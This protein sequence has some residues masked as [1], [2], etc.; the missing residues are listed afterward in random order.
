[1]IVLIPARLDSTRFPGK[2]LAPIN[3]KS[4]LQ[5]LSEALAVAAPT[6]HFSVI[7]DSKAIKAHCDAV[8]VPALLGSSA[9][10]GTERVARAVMELY[11]KL[12]PSSWVLNLQADLVVQDGFFI[13]EIAKLLEDLS[14]EVEW[15]TFFSCNPDVGTHGVSVDLDE[16][17]WV[18]DFRR[19]S[20]NGRHHLGI[21]GFRTAGAKA[22]VER[23]VCKAE[24]E[25]KLEQF[26]WLDLGARG[27][28][29]ELAGKFSEIN[30]EDDYAHLVNWR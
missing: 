12:A 27:K 4:N 19:G 7:T 13:F 8:G 6:L 5:R 10:N 20:P 22:Y 28:A 15:V 11:P 16:H 14:D 18:R 26:R 29:F 3:G 25:T 2:L 30:S 21:Y 17:G 1:M 24:T 23:G 9:V